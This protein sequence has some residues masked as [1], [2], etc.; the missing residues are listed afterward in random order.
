[1]PTLY[2]K[3]FK[4]ASS[5]RG[6]RSGFT[7]VELLIV[8]VVI[9]ILAALSYVTYSS[10]QDRARLSV[11]Q[12]D[13]TEF[14]KTMALYKA[15][16][17]NFPRS[18]AELLAAGPSVTGSVYGSVPGGYGNLVYCLNTSTDNFVFMG[19]I[20]KG[21]AKSVHIT[22]EGGIE[23]TDIWPGFSNVCGLIGA[24]PTDR[25]VNSGIGAS[26]LKQ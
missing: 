19:R 4:K 15:E 3:L 12:T 26:W 21:S 25:Y 16:K 13:M 5:L 6:D 17:G 14:K 7:I 23:V 10:L 22:S 11:A 9:A 24:S 20:V 8:I 1:M 2:H 18:S